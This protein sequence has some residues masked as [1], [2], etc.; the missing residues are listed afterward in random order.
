MTNAPPAT[1][2]TQDLLIRPFVITIRNRGWRA[3]QAYGEKFLLDALEE[4]SLSLPL[5]RLHLVCGKTDRG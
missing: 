1:A 4:Q 2:P 5:W 3:Y